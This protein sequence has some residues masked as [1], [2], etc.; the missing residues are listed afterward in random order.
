MKFNFSSII[1]LFV[2]CVFFLNTHI[3]FSQENSNKILLRESLSSLGKSSSLVSGNK[4]FF[5]MQSVNQNSV[6]GS[7][8]NEQNNYIQGFLSPYPIY[9]ISGDNLTNDMDIIVYPNPFRESFNISFNEPVYS[10]IKIEIY[11]LLNRLVYSK[12]FESNQQISVSL[13]SLSTSN[14]VLMIYVNDR[15][16]QKNIISNN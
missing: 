10:S 1:I 2:L 14:Y 16:H 8:S 13:N 15:V 12:E 6:I 11:D 5:V 3:S 9:K 4:T 7:F